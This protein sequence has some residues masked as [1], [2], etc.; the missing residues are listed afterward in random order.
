MHLNRQLQDIVDAL[1]LRLSFVDIVSPHV[2]AYSQHPITSTQLRQYSH[3]M[4]PDKDC[5][6]IRV[7]LHRLFQALPQILLMRRIF[8]NRY[9]QPIIVPQVTCL[10]TALRYALDLLNL[11]DLETC[12]LA[13]IALHEE[14]HEHRP[15]RVCVYAAAGAA[16]EGRHEE[17]CAGRGLEDLLIE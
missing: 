3:A 15:L 2:S 14:C 1:A 5:I 11:L 4:S 8:N 7:F 13:K 10:A 16:L 6:R 9:A 17:G 12:V